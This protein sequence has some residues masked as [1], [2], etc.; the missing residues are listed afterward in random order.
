MARCWGSV[1]GRDHLEGGRSG[2]GAAGDAGVAQDGREVLKQAAETVDR[3]AVFEGQGG[4]FLKR[5]R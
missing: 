1:G 3:G 2:F 4:D 5:L